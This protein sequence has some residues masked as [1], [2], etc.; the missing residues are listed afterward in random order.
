MTVRTGVLWMTAVQYFS[1]VLQFAASVIIARF[2]LGPQ[3]LGVFSVSVAFA[4]LMSALQDFGLS[5]YITTQ[6]A[7]GPEDVARLNGIA[8][9]GGIAVSG[10]ITALAHPVSAAY[11]MPSLATVL[12]V[13][14]ISNFAGAAVVVPQARL[15][16]EMFYWQCGLIQLIGAFVQAG[17]ALFLVAKMPSTTALAFA[18]LLAAIARAIAAY[19][20]CPKPIGRIRFDGLRPILRFSSNS[21]LL[22]IASAVGGRTPDLIIGKLLGFA[23]VGLFSRAASLTDQTRTLLAG[24][25]GAVLLPAFAALHHR[26]Q[27]IGPAYLRLC[28]AYTAVIWPA[29]AGLALASAPLTRIILGPHWEGVAPLLSILAVAEMILI[30]LPMVT[31]LPIL[32][33]RIASLARRNLLDNAT[34]LTFLALGC[35]W[36]ITGAALSRLIY[37]I[38][39]RAFY[40]PFMQRVVQVDRQALFILYIKSLIATGSALLPLSVAYGV[41]A[42][43]KAIGLDILSL[44][45]AGGIMAWLACLLAFNHPFLSELRQILTTLGAGRANDRVS[46]AATE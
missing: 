17:G 13:L 6:A 41:I 18:S 14:A 3:E 27:P 45:V 9:A 40:D 35:V 29:M 12:L 28:A 31:E 19:S 25:V 23:P 1:Y 16:R 43:P 46:A 15:A 44:A 38:A 4:M 33:G 37:A 42:S 26:G 5:R 24:S 39:W 21:L 10:A 2:Y 11:E 34:S 20:F 8:L 32:S 30:S 22:T 36:G 7:L